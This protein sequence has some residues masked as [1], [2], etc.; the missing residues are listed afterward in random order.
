MRIGELA[1]RSGLTAYTLRYYERIGLL[2]RAQRDGS[3]QRDY[4]SEILTWIAFLQR[5]KTTGMP[6]KQMLQYAALRAAG[7]ATEAARAKLL[8]AHRE[9]VKLHL[10]E[11]QSSLA[12]LDK[13]ISGYGVSFKKRKNRQ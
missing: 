1:E 10:D 11:L 13:K 6:L 4:D 12:V 9:S 7:P 5:L 8:M 3:G 2:P